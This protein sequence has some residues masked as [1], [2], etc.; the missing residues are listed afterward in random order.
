MNKRSQ[1]LSRKL[2]VA[3]IWG[4]LDW[5]ILQI[6]L[7]HY[8]RWCGSNIKKLGAKATADNRAEG[9]TE[10]RLFSSRVMGRWPD[11]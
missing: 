4:I 9:L 6:I 5:V 7:I 2:A 3:S 10:L 11:G 1:S 8:L